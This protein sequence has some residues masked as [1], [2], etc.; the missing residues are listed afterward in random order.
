MYCL[1]TPEEINGL[2]PEAVKIYHEISQDFLNELVALDLKS[3]ISLY[4]LAQKAQRLCSCEAGM[5][6]NLTS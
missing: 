1:T 5:P 4:G 2:Q 6:Q 3:P